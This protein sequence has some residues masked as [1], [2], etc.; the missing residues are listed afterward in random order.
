[1]AVDV[2]SIFSVC[3]DTFIKYQSSTLFIE[4]HG[5]GGRKREKVLRY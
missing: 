3:I 5:K 4:V 1:M 2:M